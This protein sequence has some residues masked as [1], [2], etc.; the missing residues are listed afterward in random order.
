MT[1]RLRDTFHTLLGLAVVVG[2]GIGG[3]LLWQTLTE[4]SGESLAR[5]AIFGVLCVVLVVTWLAARALW[6]RSRQASRRL[7]KTTRDA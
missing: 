3:V 6:R 2:V 1:N 4:R 7:F 5:G